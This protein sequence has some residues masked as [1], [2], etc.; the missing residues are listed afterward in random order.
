[1]VSQIHCLG[2]TPYGLVKNKSRLVNKDPDQFHSVLYEVDEEGDEGQPTCLNGDHTHFLLV[3]NGFRNEKANADY[4]WKNLVESIQSKTENNGLNIP[5]V[6]LLVG[7]SLTDLQKCYLALIAGIPVVVVMGTGKAADLL[8]Y[9]KTT[10]GE[11]IHPG[12]QIDCLLDQGQD[13]LSKM[14]EYLGD[15]DEKQQQDCQKVVLKCCQLG[16]KIIVFDIDTDSSMDVF[17]WEALLTG[18]AAMDGKLELALQ[19]DRADIAETRIFPR[20]KWTNDNLKET[21]RRALFEEKIDFVMLLVEKGFIMK[22]YLTVNTL[23]EL[24]SYRPSSHLNK[25]VKWKGT[26]ITITEIHH[27]LRNL[28]LK[29]FNQCYEKHAPKEWTFEDP[30]QEL[31]LWAVITRR[32]DLAF[33]L[34]EQCNLPFSAAVIATCLCNAIQDKLHIKDIEIKSEYKELKKAFEERAIKLLNEYYIDD[35]KSALSLVE[36]KNPEWGNLHPLDLAILAQDMALVS[37]Q[38][39]QAIV[40]QRWQQIGRRFGVRSVYRGLLLLLHLTMILFNLSYSLSYLEV[41]LIALVFLDGLEKIFE[42]VNEFAKSR[43]RYRWWFHYDVVTLIVF[44]TAVI[45]RL[46]P[47][48]FVFGKFFYALC[49]ILL[50]CRMLRIFYIFANLGP[51]IL[52]FINMMPKLGI[53]LVFLLVVILGYSIASRALLNHPCDNRIAIAKDPGEFIT[54]LVFLPYWQMYGELLFDQLESNSWRRCDSMTES[55]IWWASCKM[56]NDTNVTGIHNITD[57]GNVTEVFNFTEESSE[58]V[59]S[60][61]SQSVILVKI[62]LAVY[63]FFANVLLLNLIIA[64][65]T[66]VF[67]SIQQKSI[68]YWNFEMCSLAQEYE[69]KPVL[70]PP[71]APFIYLWRWMRKAMRTKDKRKMEPDISYSETSAMLS[72]FERQVR[73]YGSRS[74]AKPEDDTIETLNKINRMIGEWSAWFEKNSCAMSRE[75]DGGDFDKLKQISDTTA[76]THENLMRLSTRL[77]LLQV[78]LRD[79]QARLEY[80]LETQGDMMNILKNNQENLMEHVKANQENMTKSIKEM[81]QRITETVKSMYSPHT[82]T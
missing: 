40:D 24:Y 23:S 27:L 75:S 69:S 41:V 30:Y 55:S 47:E 48:T 80:S 20:W 26:T 14:P 52:I 10:H 74:L 42:A 6:V 45:L 63:L 17:I 5:V 71:V 81:E 68:E 79:S 82:D 28:G 2:V 1:M 78:N 39:C 33:H 60:D 9:A 49:A 73:N 15:L 12:T 76:K 38:C 57:K 53:F 18:N 56:C 11:S 3:D 22:N 64:I 77:D 72:M 58:C 62:L 61:S 65:F 54:S 13:I 35:Q 32:G 37:T 51:K 44:I 50:S 29:H 59:C 19:W 4:F 34:W 7:G 66:N 46:I 67:D 16:S 43:S 31:L 36:M 25:L 70:P 8:S 21:M